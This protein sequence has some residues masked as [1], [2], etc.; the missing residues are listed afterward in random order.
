M[1]RKNQEM[2]NRKRK[3]GDW[4]RELTVGRRFEN[5]NVEN[6]NIENRNVALGEAVAGV[7]LKT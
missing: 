2:A 6:R 7:W 3:E 5:R 4:A 1:S